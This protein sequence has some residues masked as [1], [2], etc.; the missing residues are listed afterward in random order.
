MN[1]ILIGHKARGS[2]YESLGMH[3]EA[4][5]SYSKCLELP[6]VWRSLALAYSDIDDL[7]N[8]ISAF[9]EAV[10]SGDLKSVPWLV[11]L[12][13]AHRPTDPQLPI[14][15]KQLEEGLQENNLEF[16]FSLGNLHLIGG[17]F[18]EALT[19]WSEYINQESWL[20]NRNIAGLMT[21]RYLQVGYLVP[22]PLGP[23][24]TQEEALQFFMRVNEKGFKEGIPLALVDIG[25]KYAENPDLDIFKDYSATDFFNSFMESA[26]Q[27]HDQSILMAIHF[28]S[29]FE[30]EIPDDSELL[31]LVEEY[32]LTDLLEEMA[33]RHSR[34]ALIADMAAKYSSG[35]SQRKV[36]D[37]IQEIFDRA[38]AAQKAGDPLAEITAWVEGAELGD[39]NCFHNV[40]VALCSAYRLYHNSHDA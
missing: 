19:F 32:G 5:D 34:T 3:Q 10:N 20:V 15:K 1:K 39:E 31:R 2:Y 13:Q 40:G 35:S 21:T 33:Y 36:D 17:E 22:P 38:D 28:A 29:I 30:A 6:D 14:L 8:A 9:E 24:E 16:I 26:H 11:E 23:I 7:E 27:G 18:E 4:I 37:A 25:L 12:L